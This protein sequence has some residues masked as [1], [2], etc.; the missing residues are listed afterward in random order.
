MGNISYS[1]HINT[2]DSLLKK[3]DWENF[4]IYKNPQ[5]I[6]TT[7]YFNHGLPGRIHKTNNTAYKWLTGVRLDTRLKN[8]PNPDEKYYFTY[9]GEFKNPDCEIHKYSTSDI[10]KCF[11]DIKDVVFFGDSRSRL[12]FRV[13]ESRKN[14][15]QTFF[16]EKNH[17]DAGDIKNRIHFKWSIN[18]D[19]TYLKLKEYL[20]KNIDYN[21][22]SFI[23]IGE[24]LQ[25]PIAE[26]FLKN[27]S[28]TDCSMN[29][30]KNSLKHYFDKLEDLISEN[31]NETVLVS[32]NYQFVFISAES[33]FDYRNCQCCD[34]WDTSKWD[35]ISKFYTEKVKMITLGL[36]NVGFMETN[37]KTME[38]W[39]NRTR[40]YLYSDLVHKQ[41][42]S[43]GTDVKQ[44]V[45]DS[46]RID[47]DV[48]LN[49]FCNKQLKLK[50]V[51][52]SN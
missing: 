31:K 9:S 2:C 28:N 50:D 38:H 1:N 40:Q 46:L 51:C 7:T 10:Q 17:A 22:K 33:R 39:E 34:Q 24:Q 18:F 16:D 45:V 4:K 32:E 49:Y 36:T 37:R 12:L 30:A 6:E 15:W 3:G 43:M 25:W 20:K 19:R 21:L 48:V 14:G 35:E 44:E 47:S 5:F 52:C 23:I 29:A 13:T 26:T 41:A 8:L 42:F 27:K 11:E